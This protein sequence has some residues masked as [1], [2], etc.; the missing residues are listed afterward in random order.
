[1]INLYF[2][3]SR[4]HFR[5][6]TPPISTQSP[7]ES[8]SD[9]DSEIESSL[10]RPEPPAPYPFPPEATSICIDVEADRPGD[11]PPF[12]TEFNISE[13]FSSEN[14]TDF[15]LTVVG[16]SPTNDSPSELRTVELDLGCSRFSLATESDSFLPST[17]L[18]C[19]ASDS[20]NTTSPPCSS[21][22]L[23]SSSGITNSAPSSSTTNEQLQLPSS[24][25]R[26]EVQQLT[27]I[28]KHRQLANN[29]NNAASILSKSLTSPTNN[30]SGGG[31]GGI[32]V[33]VLSATG[34]G[35]G[36]Q[37]GPVI[38]HNSN[39]NANTNSLQNSHVANN[40]PTILLQTQKHPP[41]NLL[42]GYI[43]QN[44]FVSLRQQQQS[45]AQQIPTS[46]EIT[47]NSNRSVGESLPAIVSL[48][49]K[50]KFLYLQAI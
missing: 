15:E 18:Q 3:D 11:E 14:L 10:L 7:N 28:P 22:S 48:A 1:M 12:T 41:S 46:G 25:N 44:K 27:K 33:K 49:T 20:V 5:P 6:K 43:T 34:L 24:L 16:V 39:A 32:G 38:V 37:N 36:H 29:G 31:S 30:R 4:L 8:N 9:S 26:T 40:Q 23:S 45:Q 17:R 35:N 50:K 42:P 21:S 13:Y 2:I 19:S 47:L